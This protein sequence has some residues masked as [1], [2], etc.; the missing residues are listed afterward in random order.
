MND[1]FIN[2]LKDVEPSLISPA[3]TEMSCGPGWFPIIYDV[4]RKLRVIKEGP[5]SHGAPLYLITVK[6]K[7]G[8]L[9]I[10]YVHK[11]ASTFALLDGR[12]MESV[13]KVLDEAEEKSAITCEACG[14]P[15][16]LKAMRAGARTLCDDCTIRFGGQV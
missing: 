7:F 15:G 11:P 4:V 16:K 9:R 12:L 6:Q 1:T 8:K 2:I 10:Y 14:Y 5:L 13:R 3:L